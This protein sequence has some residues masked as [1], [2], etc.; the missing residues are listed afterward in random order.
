MRAHFAVKTGKTSIIDEQLATYVVGQTCGDGAPIV[1]R[2]RPTAGR[3][4]AYDR[5]NRFGS[6]HI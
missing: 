5:F 3:R 1:V 4:D 2:K 6:E